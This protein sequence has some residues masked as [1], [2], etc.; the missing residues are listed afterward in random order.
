MSAT[1]AHEPPGAVLARY[2]ATRHGICTA[3]KPSHAA[4]A[5]VWILDDRWVLR[6]RTL[7]PGSL[8][9]FQQEQA[10]LE[11]TRTVLQIEL[12]RCVRTKDDALHV[13]HGD[14]LWT[15]QAV[16]PGTIVRP[17]QTLHRAS[18]QERRRLVQSLRHLHD[19]TRGQL[20]A[21]DWGWLI[22]D[23]S[24]RLGKLHRLISGAAQQRIATALHRV[25]EAS[26]CFGT[27]DACFVHGDYHWGNLLVDEAGDV[28][29]LLDLDWCR[30]AHP[31][32]DLAYTAMMLVRDYDAVEPRLS[33]L[34]RILGWYGLQARER[35]LFDEYFILYTLFDVHLFRDATELRD[36]ERFFSYQR[37]LLERL[38]AR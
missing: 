25:E 19:A 7:D 11:R 29:G 34:A 14:A 4:I 16:L 33:T 22:R 8:H 31:L 9:A 12:P 10:L 5:Q 17:W 28:T 13:C 15:L 30:V 3:Q 20:G 32:E 1:E 36:R 18:E 27:D 23:V 2:D 24:S 35:A 26:A 37:T 21:P 6:A 38:C